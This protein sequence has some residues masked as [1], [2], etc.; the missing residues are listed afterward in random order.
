MACRTGSLAASRSLTEGRNERP[1]GA[2][3][4]YERR[5]SQD[6]RRGRT[7][8]RSAMWPPR[9]EGS[10][11]R[12]FPVRAAVGA[13]SWVARTFPGVPLIEEGA[14]S[15]T[16]WPSMSI[17]SWSRMR[18]GP[19]PDHPAGSRA[20]VSSASAEREQQARFLE[21]PQLVRASVLEAEAARGT[22][23]SDELGD[24]DLVGR[25]RGHDAGGLVHREPPDAT[26]DELDLAEVDP[27]RTWRPSFIATD[28]S[29]PAQ[30]TAVAGAENVA[31]IPS[32]VVSISRP[33][34]RS[35]TARLD[36]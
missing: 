4:R 22:E 7:P 20:E 32:P 14:P 36:S 8:R 2:H 1:P 6:S 9:C 34:W 18:S 3:P 29:S 19:V 33:P 12:G 25:G 31:S 5:G 15:R 27:T 30:R 21:P 35:R 13:A 26:T 17:R 24:Q 28:L 16:S 23:G 11:Q 10:S